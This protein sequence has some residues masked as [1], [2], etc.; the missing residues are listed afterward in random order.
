MRNAIYLN[1]RFR[2]KH[3]L[4]TSAPY[5]KNITDNLLEMN[6]GFT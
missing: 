2:H 1:I 6:Q 5:L 4:Y 3:Y